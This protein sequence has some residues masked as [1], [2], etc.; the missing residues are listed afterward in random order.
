MPDPIVI[1]RSDGEWTAV[2][3]DGNLFDTMG[4]WIGWLDGSDVYSLE[5]EYLGYISP[6]K[7]L[8]RQRVLPYRKR[9]IPPTK[10]PEFVPPLTIPLAPMFAELSYS[11]IDVFE[12]EP[13]TF[14]L[15]S[16]L[17]PDA[18][19]RPLQRLVDTD[20]RIARKQMLRKVEQELLEEMAHGIVQSYGVTAPPVPIEA[21]AA[22]KTF[23]EA[24]EIKRVSP[25]ERVRQAE[26]LV[27]RLG[28]S[29]WAVKRGFCD[30]EGFSSL[31]I[32]YAARALLMP[33]EWIL[34]IPEGLR[35]PSDLA[36]QYAVTNEAAIL[37]LH[38]LE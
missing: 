17:R 7:R 23:Q 18:G 36:R 27:K 12:E 13:D 38:D 20:P 2:V 11:V 4:E 26:A 34:K 31:Q 25:Q 1:Y 33:R 35:H 24:T 6:D 21:M 28:L 16:E 3:C 22:A 9:R 37:R 5:G 30:V 10:T 29:D 8:L 19:E 15:V 14:A 32:A